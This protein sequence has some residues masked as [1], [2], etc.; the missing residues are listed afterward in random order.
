MFADILEKVRTNSPL[1]HCITNYVTVNDCANVLLACGASPVMAD[2]EREAEEIASIASSLVINIGT[3]NSRTIPSMFKAGKRA[4]E[5][6]HPVIL[7][8]VGA[9]ASVLRTSTAMDLIREIDFAVIR[10][11]ISEITVIAGGESKTR[12][13]DASDPWLL[14]GD[15]SEDVISMIL[16]LR[17]KTGSVI[18][19]TGAKD[20]VAGE[21]GLYIIRN[22]H[23]MMSRVT[24]TGCMLSAITGAFCA[25]GTSDLAAA[26]ASAA[27]MFGSAGE[28]A[29]KRLTLCGGGTSA[30][31]SYIIDEVSNM[32]SEKMKEVMKIEVR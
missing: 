15:L 14:D 28:L 12:G 21:K 9:G 16:E 29:F 26:A 6:G 4:N 3:L 22:G 32:T 18:T 27:A 10:G 24:G 13:V 23:P 5:L 8:P 1:V 20:I 7:D 2:D 31:R 25:A 30:Y 11:N 19:V 17:E